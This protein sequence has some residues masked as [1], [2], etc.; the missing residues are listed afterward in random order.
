MHSES[1]FD[2]IVIGGGVAGLTAA[3]ELSAQNKKV[4]LVEARNRLGGRL[5]SKAFLARGPIIEI[6]GAYFK[7]SSGSYLGTEVERYSLRLVPPIK[8]KSIK[9]FLDGRM[10]TSSEFIDQHGAEIEQASF[11]IISDSKRLI[12][13]LTTAEQPVAD[14]DIPASE[15][16]DK[17]DLSKPVRDFF[18][19]WATQYAGT[20]LNE[21]SAVSAIGLVFSRGSSLINLV[22]TNAFVFEQGTSQ[23]VNCIAASLGDVDIRLNAQVDSILQVDDGAVVELQGGACY[24][25]RTVICAIPVNTLTDIRFDPP[26]ALQQ[27]EYVAK[28]QPCRGIK[29]CVSV[30][31]VDE[32]IL[33][34]GMGGPLQLLQTVYKDETCHLIVGF[35]VEKGGPQ[36]SDPTS[37]ANAVKFL[38]PEAEV[39]QLEGHDWNN[40]PYASGAW[41]TFR[42]GEMKSSRAMRKPHGRVHFIGADLSDARGVEGALK[43]AFDVA[44]L[45][46]AH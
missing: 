43:T 37:V 32:P 11:Q 41:A 42:P 28:G 14:L 35:G 7:P 34:V 20:T 38:L 3:R 27:A 16:L 40:D 36:L 2:V 18:E 44:E 1:A 10:Y 22:S 21:I 23:L 12:L 46:K 31:G 45:L 17:L 33:R 15:Y 8:S 4:M 13:G 25:A 26:L 5:Y 24:K 39:L 6:G 19:G 9:W 30:A 29:I